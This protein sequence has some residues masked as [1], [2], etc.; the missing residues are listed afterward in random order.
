MNWERLRSNPAT[1]WWDSVTRPPEPVDAK[2]PWSLGLAKWGRVLARAVRG[3]A[4]DDFGIIASS[5]AFA[6]FL[7][8]L[9]LLSVVSLGYGALVPRDV[10]LS[11]VSTLTHILPE[12]ARSLVEDWLSKSLA[13]RDGHGAALVV[14]IGLTLFS[15]RRVGRSL[16]RGMNIA[17]GIEQDR[18]ALAAQA[19]ALVTVVAGALL[20]F[21]ALISLSGLAILGNAIPQAIPWAANAF[22]QVLWATLTLG[23][24][25]ALLLVYRYLPARA[26]VPWRWALPGALFAVAAWL[27]ATLAF[28][29]YVTRLAHYDSIYGSLS[30]IVV[31]QIWLMLSAYI[32]LFGAKVNAEAM[33]QVGL[34]APHK[35]ASMS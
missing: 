34:S 15:G 12:S 5:I 11:N 1:R 30:A 14:S 29:L 7:S 31:L 16:L 19:V 3:A 26:A 6:A 8:I 9:P 33:R 35:P 27:A 10:V 18:G 13:R 32:L 22:Q 20:L 23:P 2:G 24:S 28:Q 4:K 25:L 17:S 21:A